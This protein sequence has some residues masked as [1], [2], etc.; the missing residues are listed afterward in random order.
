MIYKQ[1]LD[2]T[3]KLFNEMLIS[4]HII[5]KAS[6]GFSNSIDLGLRT[7]LYDKENYNE[8]LQNSINLSESNKIYRF[9]DEHWCYYMF[10]KLPADDSQYFFVGPYLLDTP[11]KERLKEKL[12]YMQL[13]TS[14][15][16]QLIKYY[17]NLPI[18]EDENIIFTIMNTLGLYLWNSKDNYEIE[19]VDYAIP[20][21]ITPIEINNEIIDESPLY[22]QILEENYENE[23]ILMDAIALGK[24]NV[25]NKI[26]S[27]ILNKGTEQRLSDSLRNRKNYLIILNTLLRKAAQMG[28][29]HPL[30]I[31]KLSSEYAKKI[32]QILTLDESYVLTSEMMR[33]YCLLVKKHSLKE[34]SYLIGKAITLISYDLSAD[35]SLNSIAKQL[36][37]NPS[38]LSNLFKKECHTTLT[39]YVTQKRIEKAVNLL[40]NTDKQIQ[41]IAYECGISDTNYFIKLFKKQTGLTPSKYRLQFHK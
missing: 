31:D 38:Y 1:Q 24:L 5:D 28:E 7:I 16:P 36:N 10:L 37:V 4:T 15:L 32:E 33:N 19:Y 13:S 17:M 6:G 22:I 21:K 29:V 35:L 41:T 34:Y 27:S 8:I 18:I 30:H 26:S 23:Q 20:D 12:E 40:N 14:L 39:E 9:Y 11:S 3:M 25:I 2:F